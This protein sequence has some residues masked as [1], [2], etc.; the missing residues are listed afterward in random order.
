VAVVVALEPL[1]SRLQVHGLG[2]DGVVMRHVPRHRLCVCGVQEGREEV[3]GAAERARQH[4]DRYSSNSCRHP[5][6]T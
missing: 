1:G 3:R 4:K 6:E 2:D 5:P